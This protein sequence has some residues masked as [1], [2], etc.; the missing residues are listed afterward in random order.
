MTELCTTRSASSCYVWEIM[1]SSIKKMNK[2]VHKLYKE[3][4]DAKDKLE[5]AERRVCTAHGQMRVTRDI[6]AFH[7]QTYNY[8]LLYTLMP[9]CKC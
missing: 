8:L 6:T 7:H 4:E 5:A 2:H 1:H 9:I 3:V